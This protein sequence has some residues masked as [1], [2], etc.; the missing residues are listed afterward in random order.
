MQIC[1]EL[2]GE[3][4]TLPTAEA[5][6]A[7][8]AEAIEYHQVAEQP[9]VLIVEI[10]DGDVG[11]LG[12]V[13]E[14]LAMTHAIHRVITT[15][16]T[17]AEEIIETISG[18]DLSEFIDAD[19]TYSVRVKFARNPWDRESSKSFGFSHRLLPKLE[20]G[21]GG[22]VGS[23]GSRAD[24]GMP[25]VPFKLLLTPGIGI[26]TTILHTVDRSS[27]ELRKPQNKPFFYPGVLMPRVAR[28]LVNL[29]EVKR[30]DILLD[31]FCGTGGILVEAGLLGV[32]VIGSDVQERI[33]KG[34][35]MNLG[36]YLDDYALIYQDAADLSLRNGSV[37]A[38][39]TDP[40]YGRSARITGKGSNKLVADALSEIHRVLKEKK[41]A[42]ILYNK[43]L[44]DPL[45][46]TGFL[47]VECH[48][49]RVHRS[50]NRY[51]HLVEKP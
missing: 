4:R 9:G 10:C 22:V 1:F 32:R 39:V 41:K 23:Y 18:A 14:R 49:Q 34:A 24:L 30:G 46:H 35:G 43:P 44:L 19:Q 28:A 16:P 40:P 26:F 7:L 2:S 3:H 31:P 27:F 38:V 11:R 37:D 17:V 36:Y 33:A 13:A 50:L 29:A 15:T 51:I 48:V 21:I 45:L 20:A 12:L 47:I 6:A 5:C 42:V 25:D 8:R